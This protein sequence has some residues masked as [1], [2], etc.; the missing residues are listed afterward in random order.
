MSFG[1]Q[2][3][4]EGGGIKAIYHFNSASPGD[5]YL[6]NNKYYTMKTIIAKEKSQQKS[7]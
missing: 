2:S 5:S 1:T 6:Y 4:I 7:L 3:L